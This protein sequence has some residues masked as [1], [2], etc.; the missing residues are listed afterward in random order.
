MTTEIIVPS[1]E[2]HWRAVHIS[3]SCLKHKVAMA[4]RVA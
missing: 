3:L 4:R 2:A 1:N